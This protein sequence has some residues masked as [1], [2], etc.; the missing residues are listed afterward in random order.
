MGGRRSRWPHGRP[1]WQRG[2][3]AGV[4]LDAGPLLK[5]D[6]NDRQVAV[7]LA[8]AQ[9]LGAP[10]IVPGTAL[11]QAISDPARQA[12]LSRLLR[13]PQTRVMPLD[14]VD[15]T[16]VGRLLAVKG[17]SDIA[18]AQVV[19]CARRAGTGVVTS[20]PDDLHDLDATLR[21][22]VV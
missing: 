15:A 19:V 7:L 16:S 17:R 14:R 8:R 1:G 10:I 11:A 4:T 20:D 13:Q 12:R 18:D 3:N 2:V 9:E 6:R 5:L 22:T 21:L